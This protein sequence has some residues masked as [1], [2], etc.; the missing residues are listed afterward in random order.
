MDDG[1]LQEGVEAGMQTSY[2]NGILTLRPTE[3]VDAANAPVFEKEIQESLEKYQADTVVI[4]CDH[5]EFMSSA[6]L[7]IILRL[8][9]KIDRTSLI[10]VHPGF[11]EILDTT[12]FTELMEVKK[13][14]RVVSLEGCEL[15]GQGANGKVYRLDRENIIK[16][17]KNADALPA[18]HHG[19][20]L[21]RA[22]FVLGVPTAI[23]YDVVQI[24]EGGYGS[25]YEL[26][27]AKTYVQLLQS[28]EKSLDELVEMSTELLKLIHSRIVKQSVVPDIKDTALLWVEILK[29][30][31]PGEVYDKLY[32]MID[33]VPDDMHMLHGDYHFRNIMYQ[34]EE[35][36]L[37]D[38]DKLSHGHPVFELAA[39]YNAYC[40]FGTT[41]PSVVEE[42]LGIPCNTAAVIWR[43]TLERYL[44]TKEE[45]RL[46]AVEIR[47]RIIGHARI[48]QH[49]IRRNGQN[50]EAGR[51][52]I[53]YSRAVLEEVLPRVDTLLF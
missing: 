16:V 38:M 41:D 45:S 6:G 39:I 21:S 12:G 2:G 19:R 4:D 11:Y 52:Q 18:I 32:A 29:D 23:P 49:Y 17:Y 3:H 26:L 25:I 33:A 13:A 22:A 27:N 48:M 5:V 28:G 43:K 15:I 37:I 40:G 53:A 14:Y 8:K 44:E 20:E 42:F 31:V 51:R 47:A 24:A 10:N 35:S 34:N 1:L 9:Q 30:C 7:R 36:L 46:Q 50:T